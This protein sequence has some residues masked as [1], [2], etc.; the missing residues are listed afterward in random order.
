MAGPTRERMVRSAAGLLRSHGVRGTSIA[1]VL[2]DSG[3]PRG[4]VAHHFPG[5][6]DE[7]VL[8]AVLTAG[9]EITGRLRT[10]GAGGPVAT[11]AALCGYFADG[12]TRSGFR[13][14]CPVAAVAQEAFD[15]AP[16][17]DA[18]DRVL[19]GWLEVLTDLL[20]AG[21]R[22]PDEAADVAML[23]V[24]AVEGAILLARVRRDTRPLDAV[25]RTLQPLLGPVPDP[26]RR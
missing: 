5:G 11:V 23:A 3:A 18:A 17:R 21:G 24:S 10:L 9:E 13:A 14:G 6:K 25:A 20:V 4:S 1:R 26:G 12:L 8:D 2:A 7:L 16:L 19:A 15:T 22:D